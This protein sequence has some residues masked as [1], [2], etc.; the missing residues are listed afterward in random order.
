MVGVHPGGGRDGRRRPCAC[1][2][3]RVSL[4]PGSLAPHVA[5]RVPPRS[6]AMPEGG[7]LT[8]CLGTRPRAGV[9]D[10]SATMLARTVP[11]AP[12]SVLV[13]P[14]AWPALYGAIHR[15]PT[16]PA[17]PPTRGPA[18]TG[19]A[20]LGGCVG[21]R[22]SDRPGPEVLWR[23]VQHLGDLTAMYCLMRRD[24]PYMHIGVQLAAR[25]E[26]EKGTAPQTKMDRLLGGTRFAVSS[27]ETRHC[28]MLIATHRP[29]S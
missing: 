12:W 14:D 6:A 1:P 20:Q 17:E 15:V 26:R 11:D 28:A 2:R 21:R 22:R 7:A 5:Q 10:F 13:E 29:A 24:S 19:I 9:A 27:G 16:P 4:G 23:G 3:G 25:R 8:P 18:V